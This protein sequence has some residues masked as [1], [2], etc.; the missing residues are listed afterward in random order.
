[1]IE[2]GREIGKSKVGSSRDTVNASDMD[3]NHLHIIQEEADTMIVLYAVYAAPCG[4]KT[5]HVY[6][7]DT[8]VLVLCLH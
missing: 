3:V 5:L 1:M 8:D 4:T 2:H 6:S 7:L